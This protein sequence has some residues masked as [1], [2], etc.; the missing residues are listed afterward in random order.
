MILALVDFRWRPCVTNEELYLAY[1][2]NNN[3]LFVQPTFA[4]VY[5]IQRPWR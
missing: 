4:Y 2:N 3:Y 5:E 1:N